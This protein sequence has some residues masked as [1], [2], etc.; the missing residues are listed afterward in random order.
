MTLT[1]PALAQQDGSRFY[2]P[3]GCS[4][5]LTVQSRQCEVTHLYTCAADP[6]GHQ[7]AIS[8]DADGPT[9]LGRIDY[10]T[11]W[12]E[13]FEMFPMRRFVLVDAP[14]DPASMTELLETGIDSFDFQQCG[15]D[16][17]NRYVGF[18]RVLPGEVVIDGETLL[19]TEFSVRAELAD[20]TVFEL[21]GNEFILPRLR[22][23]LSGR[24][25]RMDTD[26]MITW[27]NSPIDFVYPGEP[28]FF[29]KTPLYECDPTLAHY[30]S[31]MKGSDQ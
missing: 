20:G 31:P 26:E 24:Y 28:G 22:R 4:E 7:W 16:G 23:F 30:A 15:P 3:A 1:V 11:Q 25:E 12:V 14:A 6:E 19:Q 27:D 29:T 9:N 13:S 5:V 18:D 17:L 2:P 10:E 8:F 21:V